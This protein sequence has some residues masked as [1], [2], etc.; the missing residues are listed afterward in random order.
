MPDQVNISFGTVGGILG[1]TMPFV[2]GCSPSVGTLY[3]TPRDGLDTPPADLTFS[4]GG[5]SI[6]LRDCVTGATFL[7]HADTRPRMCAQVFDRRWKWQFTS[8]SGKYNVRLTAG[9]VDQF[10][11]KEPGEL[12]AI[13]L[14]QMGESGY[15]V[16]RMPTGVYPPA[17]W[18]ASRGNVALADLCDYVACEVVLNPLT[19]KVE[20][21]PLGVGQETPTG[22]SENTPKW[23]YI[24]RASIPSEI[25]VHCGDSLYQYRLKLEA[26][27]RGTNLLQTKSPDWLANLN[28]AYQGLNF[29]G[30]DTQLKSALA[31]DTAWRE[32]RVVSRE[33]GVLDVPGVGAT[34]S[35][36]RQYVLKDYILYSV[37]DD[38]Y[39][40]YYKLPYYIEGDFWPYGD[41]PDNTSE[42]VYIGPSTLDTER[43]LVKF[44]YPIFKLDSSGYPTEPTLYL[45]CA[46]AVQDENGNRWRYV[47][48]Q[49]ISGSGGV[50][51]LKRPEIVAAYGWTGENTEA[52]ALA[53]TR[54]YAEIFYQK[55]QSSQASELTYR[56]IIPGSLDGRVAQ[57]VWSITPNQA[58]TTKVSEIEEHDCNSP[59]RM[60]RRRREQLARLVERGY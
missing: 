29:P 4:S 46:Y 50:L 6:T 54:K 28:V 19:D 8:V 47:Y 43:R 56:G 55:Y 42:Q 39:Q 1:L 20:I 16:S 44:P 17:N 58:P 7:R 9:T 57:A 24:P 41:T 37:A 21:W 31:M 25:Q 2:R 11:R 10:T 53:E 59:G 48:K 12:A 34:I 5:S 26:I 38:R 40:R 3:L 60:D 18:N 32:Y 35:N 27:G 45:H 13:I 49:T 23:R 15:D 36:P 30:V 33:G 51:V 14:Q 22:L 52:Q